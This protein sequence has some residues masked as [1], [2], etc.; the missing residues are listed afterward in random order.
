MNKRL[1]NVASD[2]IKNSTLIFAMIL[3]LQS[4]FNGAL[5]TIS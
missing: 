2:L 4:A 3:N 5:I 1:A